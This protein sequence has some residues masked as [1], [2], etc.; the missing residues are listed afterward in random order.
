M[1]FC[2]GFERPLYRMKYWK[3]IWNNSKMSL[4][5]QY[6]FFAFS[7]QLSDFI[8]QLSAFNSQLL[9]FSLVK[10]RTTLHQP[11]RSVSHGPPEKQGDVVKVS[12][13]FREEDCQTN[14]CQPTSKTN[15]CQTQS[16]N[17][18]IN[19]IWNYINS[20]PTMRKQGNY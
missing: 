14:S 6:S 5:I 17:K 12:Q 3:E 19:K 16:T 9:T 20:Y 2:C 13:F 10:L 4:Y 11:S 7:H 1:G 8:L 18:F 15:Y